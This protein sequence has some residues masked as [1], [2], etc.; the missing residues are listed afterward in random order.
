MSRET[1]TRTLL[2]TLAVAAV[3]V[4][5]YALGYQDGSSA[6]VDVRVVYEESGE[7]YE[8]AVLRGDEPLRV[9][10]VTERWRGNNAA[11]DGLYDTDPKES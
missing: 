8:L 9:E 2:A 11:A 7:P 6:P 1:I 10:H 5:A 3:G 4:S